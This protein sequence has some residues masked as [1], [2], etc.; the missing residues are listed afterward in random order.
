[1]RAVLVRR[2]GSP[3]ELVLEEVGEPAPRQGEV[4]IA[5]R[6]AGVNFAEVAGRR[7]SLARFAPPF[8]PGLEVAGEVLAVGDGVRDL[9]P[10]QAV[11]AFT[12]AGGYAEVAVAD[13]ALTFPIPAGVDFVVAACLPVVAPTARALLHWVARLAEGEDVL[14]HAAAGGVGTVAGQLARAAGADRVLGVVGTAEKARYASRFGYDRV[15]HGAQWA[16]EARAITGGRGVDLVLDSVGGATRE[17]SFRLLAPLGRMA[18][19]GNSGD[20]PETGTPGSVLRAEAKGVL[21]FSLA[22]LAAADPARAGALMRESAP[23]V[24]RGDVEIDVAEVL[25]LEDVRRA[26]E[27]LEG[28]RTMGKL[29]LA[30]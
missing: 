22:S 6:F 3:E 2:F 10:G 30:V 5:V 12:V 4:A 13:A 7:G 23:A 28:R 26:H 27:L 21:G 17:E 1:V 15:L 8:I 16:G 20:A 24:A 14:I 29:V 9:R 18:I 25:P 11:A 19:F